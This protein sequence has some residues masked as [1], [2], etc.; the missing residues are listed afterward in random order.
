[1]VLFLMIYGG[2]CLESDSINNKTPYKNI[3][4]YFFPKELLDP[5]KMKMN[6]YLCFQEVSTCF[7]CAQICR[8]YGT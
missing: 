3:V 5:S 4:D 2:R 6:P 8:Y 7:H 1:M